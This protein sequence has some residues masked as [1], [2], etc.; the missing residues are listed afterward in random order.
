MVVLERGRT[1]AQ[2]KT[3]RDLTGRGV[4]LMLKELTVIGALVPSGGSVVSA[5]IVVHVW[6]LPMG[7]AVLAAFGSCFDRQVSARPAPPSCWPWITAL[8]ALSVLS[9]TI[10]PS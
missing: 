3:R 5:W 8:L 2:G 10:P 1:I 6:H 9:R 4:C 7:G